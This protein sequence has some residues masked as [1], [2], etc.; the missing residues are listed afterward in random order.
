[1][2]QHRERA[3]VEA[4]LNLGSGTD[5][6]YAAGRRLGDLQQPTEDRQRFGLRGPEIRARG[7]AARARSAARRGLGGR[8]VDREES[9]AE[10][11][12]LRAR[13]IDVSFGGALEERAAGPR[14]AENRVV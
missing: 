1:M 2:Q 10:T 7:H 9:A 6:L 5:N 12:L 14:H 11:P 3:A 4:A 13:Q 8:D